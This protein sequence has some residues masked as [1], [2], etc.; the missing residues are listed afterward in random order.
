M[1]FV[2]KTL[3][4]WEE[5][6][7]D[8]NDAWNYWTDDGL[9]YF[10]FLQ[11]SEDHGALPIWVFNIGNDAYTCFL[12]SNWPIWLFNIVQV[13]VSEYAVYR[14]DAGK[15]SLLA[16]LGEAG[17]LSGRKGTAMPMRIKI[18]VVMFCLSNRMF[19]DVVAMVCYALLFVN[20]HDRRSSSLLTICIYVTTAHVQVVNFGSI[21]VKL[22]ISVYGLG[23]N[24]S[25]L[26]KIVLTSNNVMDENSLNEPNKVV[27]R[28]TTLENAGKNMEVVVSPHSITSYDLMLDRQCP[29]L[30]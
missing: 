20:V 8:F 27:P 10:E 17:F 16:A 7:G 11:L 15:G 5:R 1:P 19:N 12:S 30:V 18:Q 24:S 2:G 3:L 9:D 6:P 14:E 21:Q 26:T 13:S 22:K 29:G 25:R 4:A 28:S 23:S